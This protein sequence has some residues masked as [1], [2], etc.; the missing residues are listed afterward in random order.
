MIAVNLFA[1]CATD[2]R[3]LFAENTDPVGG[4]NDDY[5]LWALRR[6]TYAIAGWGA[7]GDDPLVKP[8]IEKVKKL[9]SWVR[10]LHCFGRTAKGQPRHPLYLRKTAKLE[11]WYP[12]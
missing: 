9:A 1:F 11:R 12:A 8:R 3:D 7:F 10:P 4:G 6:S 2:P 5:I